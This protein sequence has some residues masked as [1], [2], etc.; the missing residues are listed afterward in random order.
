M[1]GFLAGFHGDRERGVAQLQDVAQRGVLNKYDAQIL[2]AIVYR[3]ER[4]LDDAI[5]LLNQICEVFP[6][7]YLLRLEQ[8]QMYSDAGDKA[9]ALRVLNEV[10][11]MRIAGVDGFESLP[12]VKVKYVRGNLLFWYGDFN[13]ALR[14]MQDATAKAQDLDLN[15]AV[16]AWLRLGQLYDLQGNHAE[17]VKAYRETMRTAP[18]STAA[19]EAKGYISSP[20]KR[21]PVNG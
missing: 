20:Y 7:N 3:R 5:P 6:H 12:A 1:L 18:Q 9:S 11:Q 10:E 16:L 14:D 19:N 17:A 21:K 2:L 8:V 15:T 4:R 13:L